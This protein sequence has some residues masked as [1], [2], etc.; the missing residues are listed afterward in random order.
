MRNQ[1]TR[2]YYPTNDKCAGARQGWR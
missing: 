2:A 1:Y